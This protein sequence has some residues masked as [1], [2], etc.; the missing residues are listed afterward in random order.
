M[1][2]RVETVEAVIFNGIEYRRYPNS[3]RESDRRYYRAGSSD[4]QRGY[5]YLH[6]D[7][8]QHY[9]GDIPDG[10]HIHHKDGNPAN[11]ALDNLEC[12]SVKDHMAQ[13]P[14]PEERREANQ[15]HMAAIQP[16]ATEWHRSSTG[17]EWHRE[18]GR[19]VWRKRTAQKR[20]CEYCGKE[21]ETKARHGH[22]RFCSNNCKSYA[23]NASGVDDEQ[24]ICEWCG[25]PFTVNRYAK[26]Q[27]CS[28]SCAAYL[29]NQR[30]ET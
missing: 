15:K 16:L 21:Y 1:P 20:V 2:K 10:Y 23:R 7:K 18:H 13:H 9:N 11:N 14:I 26:K 27:C 30:R 17:R 4:I 25:K 6:R 24:R 28:R 29:R 5:G 8:W 22:E 3:E 19:Q 12:L